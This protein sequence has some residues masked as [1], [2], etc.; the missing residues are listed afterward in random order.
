MH[1]GHQGVE[2]GAN[3]ES[4]SELLKI[5]SLLTEDDNWQITLVRWNEVMRELFPEDE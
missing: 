5:S 1:L 3:R 4:S 2:A